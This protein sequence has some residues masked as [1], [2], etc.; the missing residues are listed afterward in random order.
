[1]IRL[2]VALAVLAPAAAP[3]TTYVTMADADLADRATVVAEVRVTAERSAAGM[4]AREHDVVVEETVAGPA[5]STMVVRIPGDDQREDGPKLHLPGVPQL[6][7]GERAL[8]FLAPNADG[9]WRPI[10]LVSASSTTSVASACARCTTPTKRRAAHAR[11]RSNAPV[12]ETCDASAAGSPTALPASSVR[13]TT[14]SLPTPPT[15]SRNGRAARGASSAGSTSTCHR[16]MRILGADVVVNEGIA[17]FLESSPDPRAAAEELFGHE[18]GHT[19]GLGHAC[20]D[21]ASGDCKDVDGDEALMRAYVH[22][23]GRGAQLGAHDGAAICRLY[24]AARLSEEACAR[25]EGE[26]GGRGEVVARPH[27]SRS[28]SSPLAASNVRNADAARSPSACSQRAV[29]ASVNSAPAITARRSDVV[30]PASR[31]DS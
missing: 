9:T 12:R 19:L 29:Y 24:P 15:S 31:A 2:L 6:A 26:R 7:V 8:V 13:P 28:S 18:L 14:S 23:D 21:D 16:Y 20:G 3:A 10:H 4:A 25:G 5:A 1:M 27:A 30:N 17:C 22:D 11:R